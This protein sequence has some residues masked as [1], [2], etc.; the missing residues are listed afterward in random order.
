MLRYRPDL[1]AQ[2]SVLSTRKPRH[3]VVLFE[4]SADRDPLLARTQI[5][6][7][8]MLLMNLEHSDTFQIVTAG[9]RSRV[10]NPSPLAALQVN[11]DSA[12]KQLE[13]TQLIGAFDLENA[14]AT[15]DPLLVRAMLQPYESGRSDP[16]QPPPTRGAGGVGATEP[17]AKLA[18]APADVWLL[19]LGSG[20]PALGERRVDRLAGRIPEGVHYAGIGV[21]KRWS[22]AFMKA[23]AERTGGHY[24][25]INPD[26]LVN[27]R[28]FDF[29]AAL[30]LPRLQSLTATDDS[31]RQWLLAE[32]S[33]GA[34][35]ELCA[36][37]RLAVGDPIP[38]RV[39]IRGQLEGKP[40]EKIFPLS[41]AAGERGRGEGVFSSNAGY[42]PRF[43]GRL[44]IDRLLAENAALN[45]QAI[46]DLSKSLYVMSPYT[47]LLVLENEQMYQQ[48]KID[49]G[50]K[51]HWAMYACPAH[52]DVQT[53][54]LPSTENPIAAKNDPKRERTIRDVLKSIMVRNVAPLG[55][56]QTE[57]YKPK[58]VWDL[59]T[60]SSEIAVNVGANSVREGR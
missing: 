37:T 14:L 15:A 39:T 19:H 6:I 52:I 46:I 12:I 38:K 45:K 3:F 28:A 59:M 8:R 9:T 20:I 41:P 5:E 57:W 56:P 4:S 25:Q 11:I 47:S 22:R 35:E 32:S 13:Y 21:G 34:G 40:F 48:Y 58:T 29:L 36:T 7:L 16:P 1:S 54:P 33:L 51:D 23:A 31:G 2:Y 26:E 53:E 42:I 18:A 27:W 43:W 30:Q 49:R 17:S 50:R 24:T 44:E 60:T 10:L 55:T